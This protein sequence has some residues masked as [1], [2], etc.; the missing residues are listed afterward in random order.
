MS[1]EFKSEKPKGGDF[2]FKPPSTEKKNGTRSRLEREKNS[3][4]SSSHLF[5]LPVPSPSFGV[6]SPPV[7]LPQRE[8]RMGTVVIVFKRASLFGLETGTPFFLSFFA[9]PGR[10]TSC[11]A[12]TRSREGRV[13]AANWRFGSAT[14]GTLPPPPPPLL[15]L[16]DTNARTWAR[17]VVAR[18]AKSAR[19]AIERRIISKKVGFRLRRRRSTE[20]KRQ[21]KRECVCRGIHVLD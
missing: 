19:R 12:H 10:G 13:L 16:F 1:G 17:L 9:R 6:P 7:L 8:A 18:S 3:R 21:T 5:K 2:C 4:L 11:A 20:K 15:L 14:N